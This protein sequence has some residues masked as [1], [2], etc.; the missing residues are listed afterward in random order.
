MPGRTERYW[1]KTYICCETGIF[2]H[3]SGCGEVIACHEV[4]VNTLF[5]HSGILTLFLSFLIDV[6]AFGIG[7]NSDFFVVAINHFVIRLE[8]IYSNILFAVF[9]LDK[10]ILFRMDIFVN[11]VGGT[12][13]VV[14]DFFVVVVV[15]TV[16]SNA[17]ELVVFWTATVGSN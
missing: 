2:L 6:N 10:V 8:T 14:F 1:I 7:N 12:L 13:S 5:G 11:L 16:G 4:A 3:I 9:L 17:V 15:A